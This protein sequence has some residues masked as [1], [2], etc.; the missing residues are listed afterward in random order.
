MASYT[1]TEFRVG[2]FVILAAFLFGGGIFWIA[3]PRILQKTYTVYVDFDYVKGLSAGSMV[4]CAGVNIGWVDRMEYDLD[5]A[6]VRITCKIY[7]DAK[8]RKDAEARVQ[9]SGIVGEYYLEATFGS[10]DAEYLRDGGVIRGETTYSL[11]DVTQ[12]LYGTLS[13]L[14][15]FVGNEQAQQDFYKILSDGA[16]V[17]ERVKRILGDVEEATGVGSDLR[18]AV[19]ELR[20]GAAEFRSLA[21][22]TNAMVREASP[23]IAGAV[24]DVSAVTARIR[25]EL[26]DDAGYV[27]EQMRGVSEDLRTATRQMSSVFEANRER[28]DRILASIDAGAVRFATAA[29][30]VDRILEEAETGRGPLKRLMSDEEWGESVD[31]ILGDAKSTV[32]AVR[33]LTRPGFYYEFRAFEGNAERYADNYVRN[34]AG[35]VWRFTDA[36]RV[37]IGANDIGGENEFELTYGHTFWK[38]LTPYAGVIE[39]EAAVGLDLRLHDR[40][41]VFG[42]G[43]GLTDDDEERLDLFGELKVHKHGSLLIGV[44]DLCDENYFTGGFR[45][46]I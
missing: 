23:G 9:S 3:G 27:V 34:D 12:E 45:L 7:R 40:F 8:L 46:E 13:S 37:T 2:V 25:S 15:A 24:E 16:E 36:D 11:E 35:I 21:A 10:M 32:G 5:R 20:Q 33:A 31:Q 17:A 18:G 38:L 43:I 22:A 6:K 41:H 30:R 1:R 28:V 26:L 39:S 19:A 4:K 44:E 14:Q 42:E 29:A